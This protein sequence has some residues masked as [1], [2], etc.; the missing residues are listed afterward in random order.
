MGLN[1]GINNDEAPIKRALWLSLAVLV[2]V[3]I[4]V[5]GLLLYSDQPIQAPE[6]VELETQG[7]VTSRQTPVSMPDFQ[8]T[9]ITDASGIRFIHEN[10]AYGERLLPETMGGG[11]AF[12]DYDNDDH[13]DLLL[14]NS[15]HWPWHSEGQDQPT[16]HLYKGGGDGTF[17]DVTHAAGLDLS[18]Y[19]MGVAVGDYD[20]DNRTD[21]FIT[22]VGENRL[23]RNMD[24]NRFTDVT[25]EMGVA[26]AD[27]DWSTG[28]AFLDYDRD[29]DLDL[30]VCHYVVWSREINSAVDYRLT[31]IGRAY[32]PPNDFAGTQS[33]L[34]RNDGTHF[35]DVSQSAGI[36]VV[37]EAT[38]APTGK[39]LAVHPLDVNRDGWLDLVVANDTVRNFLFL[40]MQNGQ[41]KE[42]GIEYG[43]AFDTG[44]MATGA[45]GIDAAYFANDDRLAVAIGNF[46]NEMSSF[47]VS[48]H[49]EQVFSDDAIV[50]GIGADSRRVL[51]F[52]LM[53]V[54]LDLDGR[55]DLLAANG[56]VEPAINK[57]Q[58]SQQYAQ[59]IQ[60]Y[61]NC[62]DAC[63]RQY[64]LVSQPMDDIS[65]PLV[66][67][68]AAYGDLD[69]D[70]DPDLVFTAVGGKVTLLR[71]DQKT[72]H[73]WITL[74][75]RGELPNADAI[76][77][78]V[79]L[80]ADGRKQ[81][82]AVMPARSY[83]SQMALPLTMGLG[84]ADSADRVT[85]TWPD[86]LQESWTDLKADQVY[87]LNKGEG[88]V[89]PG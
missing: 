71:N 63:S 17:A 53:F 62:G 77:A 50:A 88:R 74:K 49:N 18:L 31:G 23:L 36:H 47:Y 13:L 20:G 35:T 68:G 15:N 14:I 41:F 32:G 11:V 30:F 76:G 59:P 43:L 79:V 48:R 58:S 82:Q 29:G 56:H 52:G 3:G 34:Y 85:V 39:G 6:V 5:A 65:R 21:L 66:G 28:A 83:L 2:L 54:D 9:D 89:D 12:L 46:A 16:M 45:M 27:D 38:G 1:D 42:V 55:L 61:W 73:H 86:G 25:Q 7:P 72:G 78:S 37:N 80:E 64:R 44:G 75:L 24:G 10:G 87:R 70:G 60:I 57:V 67:R 19:G 81:Y 51:T 69:H 22:A 84:K 4:A 8:F 33:V 40:N 26:G